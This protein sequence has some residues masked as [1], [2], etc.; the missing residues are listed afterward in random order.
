MTDADT[1]MRLEIKVMMFETLIS[2]MRDEKSENR[3][4][5]KAVE[6]LEKILMAE[7]MPEEKNT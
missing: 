2:I 5:L 4:R 6:L 3:D 1:K 7:S